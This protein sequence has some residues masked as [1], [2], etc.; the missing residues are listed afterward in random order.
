MFA[1]VRDLGLVFVHREGHALHREERSPRYHAREVRN[2]P[3]PVQEPLPLLVGGGGERVTLRPMTYDDAPA[4]MQAHVGI[5]RFRLIAPR[6]S[7][8]LV[9]LHEV[10]Q[11][12]ICT[13][14]AASRS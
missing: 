11:L 5:E 14:I 6:C 10:C 12:A 1:P 4:L 8:L 9:S 13:L 2:D 3:L 7:D